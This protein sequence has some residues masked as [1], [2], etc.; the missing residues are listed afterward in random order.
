MKFNVQNWFRISLANLF[1]VSL[2]GALMRYKIGFE[3]PYFNQ[4]YIQHAHSHF[5]F[6]GWIGQSIYLLLVH[7]LNRNSPS[8]HYSPFRIV[9]MANLVCAYGMLFSFF[10]QGYSFVSISFSTLSIVLACRFA[11]LFFRELQQQGLRN[12]YSH[13]FRAAL[14]FNIF[15]SIG[16]FYLAYIMVSRNFN[17]NW[18]L[19]AIYFYLHFQYNG[20][21]LFSCMGLAVNGLNRYYPEY[22]IHPYLFRLFFWTAIPAYFLSVLWAGLPGWLYAIVVVAAITQ[23]LPW[24]ML[25]RELMQL[26]LYTRLKDNL[27]YL[28][29][30]FVIMAYTA[31]LLLQ[32]GSTIP[33]VSKLAF[34]F[35]PV[36]IAYLHLVLLAVIS[37][38]LLGYAYSTGVL[39]KNKALVNGILIFLAGVLLNELLLGLQG[40]ASFS[41]VVVPYIQLYLFL[42]SIV[43]LL[44]TALMM[45]SQLKKKVPVIDGL[46]NKV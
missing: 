9:L 44:G 20:F 8:F 22:T 36:V 46:K 2:L 5:A 39:L 38:F 34:G 25:L 31:K 13:W 4:K 37:V 45:A 30:S 1:L 10:L 26:K 3:F 21:F 32:L 35:R 27:I 15:S 40:V 6:T 28:I 41:Y 7:Y 14:W 16:T 12:S 29:F 24:F 18:Y 33:M 42:I 19:A 43:L 17:E 23:L 11:Y